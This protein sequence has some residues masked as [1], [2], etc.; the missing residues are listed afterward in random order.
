MHEKTKVQEEGQLLSWG[1]KEKR[2]LELKLGN[3]KYWVH[4]PFFPL[5]SYRD[6]LRLET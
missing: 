1:C 2:D 5:I 6:F 3:I 4:I